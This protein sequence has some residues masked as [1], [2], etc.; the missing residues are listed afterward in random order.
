M[1]PYHMALLLAYCTYY[2]PKFL[3]GRCLS[4][5]HLHIL[6]TWLG[7][8]SPTI[9]S[10]R[11][12]PTL[13]LHLALAQSSGL[14]TSYTGVWR[15]TPI[16]IEW[17]AADKPTQLAFLILHLQEEDKWKKSLEP[18]GLV[19]AIGIDSHAYILQHLQYQQAKT[20]SSGTASWKSSSEEEWRLQLP[21]DLPL[22][23][24]FD[25]VQMGAWTPEI[26]PANEWV[27][28]QFSIAQVA[29]AGY[30]ITQIE[31]TLIK[32]TG[33]PLPETVKKQLAIWYAAYDSY[34][35]KPVYLLSVKQVEQLSPVLTHGLMKR[36][37]HKQI[38]RRHALVSPRIIPGL[39][40]WLAKQDIPLDVPEIKTNDMAAN[41]GMVWLALEVLRGLQRMLP[42]SLPPVR[43]GNVQY[44]LESEIEESVQ[45]E[46]NVRS[47]QILTAVEQAIRGRDAFFPR[48]HTNDEQILETIALAFTTDQLLDIS[49]RG[50]VDTEPILRRVE[51]LRL[52]N[53]HNLHYLHAYCHHAEANRIFRIDRVRDCQIV[54]DSAM[55]KRLSVERLLPP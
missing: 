39:R 2:T 42:L 53:W 10:A 11:Q 30:G 32:A 8:S 13:A 14:V 48:L 33:A 7:C 23:T 20:Y 47:D 35:V 43:V 5:T 24:L 12:H 15:V 52:E 22:L 44:D 55:D 31:Y 45:V 9:R 21:L 4:A 34:K 36:H 40:K 17:L 37:V 16:G 46:M 38:S 19:D 27:A 26:T 1:T 18:L 25:L 41:A 51:P 6:S 49:Y 3:S 50:L 29:Q 54:A 28:T